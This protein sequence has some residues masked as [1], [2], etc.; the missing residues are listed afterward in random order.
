MRHGLRAGGLAAPLLA[1]AASTASATPSVASNANAVIVAPIAASDSGTLPDNAITD[2]AGQRS[3]TEIHSTLEAGRMA[4]VVSGVGTVPSESVMPRL[5]KLVRAYESDDAPD[6]EQKCLAGA[7]YFEARGE[8][9][10]GQLA[11][12]EV[13][14]NRAASGEYPASICEVVTQPAQFSFVRDGLFPTINESSVA[15]HTA[16]AV[17]HIADEKLANKL[18]SDVLWYHADYVAPSWDRRL[19]PVV[20]IGAHIFYRRA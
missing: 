14:L 15:W 8:P 2:S 16:L 7:I 10:E 19:V 4:N 5:H 1:L 11:V 18:E 6:A 17:A 9:L 12:A 3:E 20:R 13:V